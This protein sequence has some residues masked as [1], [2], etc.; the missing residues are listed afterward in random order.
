[1][2]AGLMDKWW[3]DTVWLKNQW[4]VD[5]GWTGYTHVWLVDWLIK[6]CPEVVVYS[7][8][9]IHWVPLQSTLQAVN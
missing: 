7:E 8:Q 5:D 1:M 9:T 4:K 3:L 2:N 6:P